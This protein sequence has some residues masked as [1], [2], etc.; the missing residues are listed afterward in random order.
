MEGIRILNASNL[1]K[2]RDYACP[3]CPDTVAVFDGEEPPTEC[4]SCTGE[5]MVPIDQLE[6]AR[7]TA[8][9]TQI[10]IS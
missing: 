3:S 2:F 10:I 1:K 7:K 4:K 5:V 9:Q 8:P 6:E